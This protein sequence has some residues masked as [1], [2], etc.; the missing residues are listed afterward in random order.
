VTDCSPLN[1]KL[2][3]SGAGNHRADRWQHLIRASGPYHHPVRCP[4]ANELGRVSLD[5]SI[6]RDILSDY[7]PSL[8]PRVVTNGQTTS[9]NG[10]ASVIRPP[11]P[12]LASR[13]R[14]R[15]QD[16]LGFVK[17]ETVIRCS[18][19][20]GHAATRETAAWPVRWAAASSVTRSPSR[21]PAA[22]GAPQGFLQS[23]PGVV[24]AR[25][26][27][28]G[29]GPSS[30]RRC[31]EPRCERAARTPCALRTPHAAPSGSAGRS[32]ASKRSFPSEPPSP[33]VSIHSRALVGA[34]QTPGVV[35]PKAGWGTAE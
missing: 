28:T 32:G 1:H 31:G 24:P 35:R 20:W 2:S 17:P 19:A 33:G 27:G 26:A 14:P 25:P 8:D 12:G 22:A 9:H 13:V 6:C 23:S 29:R 30:G 18:D 5:H 21:R 7:T 15:W 11:A 4:K 3:P 10:E 34:R 16:A